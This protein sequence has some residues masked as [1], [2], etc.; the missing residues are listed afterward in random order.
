MDNDYPICEYWGITVNV[1]KEDKKSF[2]QRV[3]DFFI[4]IGTFFKN[5]FRKK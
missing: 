3:A 5:L 4:A 1:S 2:W